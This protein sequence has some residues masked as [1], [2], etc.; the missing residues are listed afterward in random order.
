MRFQS[1]STVFIV[2]LVLRA[3][4]KSRLD[5]FITW[6]EEIILGS[7]DL[8]LVSSLIV[9]Y[10]EVSKISLSPIGSRDPAGGLRNNKNGTLGYNAKS[11]LGP[12]EDRK[13]CRQL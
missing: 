7:A 11:F 6:G 3:D 12:I 1:L 13:I 5:G 2:D 4:T 9:T 10:L 8:F